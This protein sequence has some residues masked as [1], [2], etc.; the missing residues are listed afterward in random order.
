MPEYYDE[1]GDEVF[2]AQFRLI[3][4]ALADRQRDIENADDRVEI[5]VEPYDR[6]DVHY[7]YAVGRL[8]RRNDV[9]DNESIR[10]RVEELIPGSRIVGNP[11][12]E[13]DV[14]NTGELTVQQALERLDDTFGPGVVTPDHV[15][16]IT[17]I[18][19]CPA[20][21]PDP[22]PA[23]WGPWPPEVA[24]SDAGRD[25]RI[26]IPDRGLPENPP[27]HSWLS[28]VDGDVDDAVVPGN[29]N[30][31]KEYAGHGVFAAGVAR[32]AAPGS[33]VSVG[34]A[35][36]FAGA[37]LESF[38]ITALD[39]AL[40]LDPDII[41][42]SAGGYTRFDL[43]SVIGQVFADRLRSK[44]KTILIAAAGNDGTGRRFWP[45]A[46]SGVYGVGA[47]AFDEQSRAW[48]SNHGHWVDVWTLGDG[49]VNAYAEG[50]Y[51]YQEPPKAPFGMD[52]HRMA[53]WSGTSFSAPL[54]AGLVAARMTRSG[55]S[56]RDA[57]DVLVKFAQG[58]PVADAGPALMFN[59]QNP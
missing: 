58:Q 20:V 40:K 26:V 22:I 8:L 50:R 7:Q 16:S 55:E 33:V 18:S 9:D 53:R 17:G 13:I 46:H 59:H 12:P 23:G 32:C 11:V 38:V 14:I 56:S 21:E 39:A 42:L 6:R 3:Q 35:F 4:A 34:N 52:F 5:A 24:D 29:P 27:V 10:A 15:L 54:F 25:V 41:S 57:A 45:A 48:F 31:L 36:R 28:G 47:L 49:M 2:R 30:Q 37:D 19:N 1:M 43:P 44:P 51:T